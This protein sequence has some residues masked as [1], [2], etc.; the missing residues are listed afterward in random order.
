M[1]ENKFLP[2]EYEGKEGEWCATRQMRS[3]DDINID[4]YDPNVAT[5]ASNAIA[6]CNAD[7]VRE[8]VSFRT[9]FPSFDFHQK[10]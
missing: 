5:N 2:L 3:A 4:I 1:S 9:S 7:S 8:P 10:I 6:V